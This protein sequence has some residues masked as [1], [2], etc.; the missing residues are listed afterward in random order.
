MIAFFKQGRTGIGGATVPLF[1]ED[2]A[3]AVFDALA[4]TGDVG[5]VDSVGAAVV[6]GITVRQGMGDGVD[7]GSADAEVTGAISRQGRGNGSHAA[8]SATPATPATPA[9]VLRTKRF[10]L[11]K[12]AAESI[13]SGSWVGDCFGSPCCVIFTA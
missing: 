4:D 11:A 12:I 5:V 8:P 1:D 7:C 3:G 6:G 9:T 13:S 10:L 2:A